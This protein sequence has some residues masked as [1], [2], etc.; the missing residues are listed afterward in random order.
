[1]SDTRDFLNALF[2]DYTGDITFTV[3]DAPTT[4]AAEALA[5]ADAGSPVYILAR[6]PDDRATFVYG[7]ATGCAPGEWREFQRTPTA[8]LFRPDEGVVEGTLIAFWAFEGPFPTDDVQALADGLGCDLDEPLPLP[9]SNGWRLVEIDGNRFYTLED[10]IEAYVPPAAEEPAARDDVAPEDDATDPLDA[11]EPP[12][13]PLDVAPELPDDLLAEAEDTPPWEEPADAVVSTFGDAIVMTPGWD[14]QADPRLAQAYSIAQGPKAE[15][16]HWKTKSA[17]LGATI[18]MLCTHREG[19]KD[20]PGFVGGEVIGERRKAQAMKQI[21]FVGLDIDTGME[22]EKIDAALRQLGCVAVRYTTHSNMKTSS[23]FLKSRVVKFAQAN[24]FDPEDFSVEL[25]GAFMG[26]QEKFESYIVDSIDDV[27]EDQTDRGFIIRVGHCPIPKNRIVLPMANPFVMAKEASS[28]KDAIDKWKKVP[29]ALAQMIGVPIDSTGVDPSRLFY[30]PR[31]KR[32]GPFDCRLFGGELFDW[33]TLELDDPYLAAAA[34]MVKTGKGRGKSV[35][36]EGRALGKWAVARAQ[37]FQI[38]DVLREHCEDRIRAE[39]A[40]GVEIECPFDEDHGNAGD[41]DDRA[42][43]A[44]NAGDGPSEVFTISC[45]HEGCQEKTMLDMLGKMVKDGWFPT[46]V[47]DSEEHNALAPEETSQPEQAK[48]IV[49]QRSAKRS[50]PERLAA[51]TKDF[52]LE[53]VKGIITDAA[54]LDS[55]ELTNALRQ[56][57][58]K[59]GLPLSELKKFATKAKPQPSDTEKARGVEAGEEVFD[60]RDGR[61]SFRY[62]SDFNSDEAV[63]ACERTLKRCNE[64]LP[65]FTCALDQPVRLKEDPDG[66]LSWVQLNEKAFWSALCKQI[67]FMRRTDQGDGKREQ[68]PKDIVAELYYNADSALPQSPEIIYTPLF[69]SKGTLLREPGWYRDYGILMADTGFDVPEVSMAPSQEEVD[70]SL[71]ILREDVLGDFPFLDFDADGRERRECSEANALAYLITPFM[72]R[73]IR[74]CTPVFFVTKPTPGTGGTLLANVPMLL[75]DGA[76]SAPMRYNAHNDEEMQ[77]ALLSAV[78][79]GRTFLFYDDVR[80]FRSQALVQ[81]IT[82]EKIGGR[83]LGRT[84]NVERPNNFIWSGTGNNPITNPDMDRRCCWIRLNAKTPDIQRRK[85]RH[86]DYDGYMLENRARIVHAILTLIQNWM[87][88]G[89]PRFTDRKLVSFEEWGAMVGGVINEAWPEHGFLDNRKL[90][91][92]DGDQAALREF[93]SEWFK[94]FK[95]EGTTQKELFDHANDLELDFIEGANDQQKRDRFK[96]A[97]RIVDGMSFVLGDRVVMGRIY[98]DPKTNSP[99]FGLEIMP[100]ASFD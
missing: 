39:V 82:S 97:V 37:G 68:P 52:D 57:K 90:V 83:V 66:R 77:K 49:E 17:P 31:H 34:D 50:V 42:C 85:F 24:G 19:P 67:Y 16:I 38:V 75:F 26:Q 10:L 51:L 30:Y 72:R 45:R 35:T 47:I 96:R 2:G 29:A 15:S 87:A 56:I 93:V 28:Q 5:A 58:T 8:A 55:I 89:Q 33:R 21:T 79:E 69:S 22:A 84:V 48:R 94:R 70:E 18:A 99:L 27:E 71:R 64:T 14:P 59:T 13:E 20:G 43:L 54:K 36:D 73:M 60:K 41:T 32:N 95:C 7:V 92:S 53:E 91:S 74:G 61:M 81:S 1:M 80:E 11:L 6:T 46:E 76:K 4:D 12:A 44:V 100:D 3:G 62:Y 86:D 25:L 40:N 65:V 88:K 98:N 9:D 23:E 63:G 78:V